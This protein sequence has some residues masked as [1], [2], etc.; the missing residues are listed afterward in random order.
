M[1]ARRRGN[2]TAPAP[3]SSRCRPASPPRTRAPVVHLSLAAACALCAALVAAD[4]LARTLRLLLFIRGAGF[5][6]SAREVFVMNAF[7]DAAAVVTPMR[8]GGEAARAVGL[9][10][11]RV[12]L[13]AVLPLLA[14][15][16][17]AYT[18]VIGVAAVGVAAWSGPDWWAEVGVRLGSSIRTLAPWLLAFAALSAL[19]VVWAHGRRRDGHVVHL[20]AAAA[21]LRGALAWPLAASVPL[22]LASA[23]ARIAILPV[24]ALTLA[25]P[26]A[27]DVLVLS[28]F[29]LVYGQLLLPTPAGAGA[30]EIAFAADAT[31]DLGD[32][33]GPVF[34]AWRFFVTLVPVLVGFGVA[35]PA[36][37]MAALRVLRPRAG[38]EAR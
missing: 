12:P 37:G 16:V 2:E 26:P 4:M 14:L 17:A 28:S 20:R 36:Y 15:E 19:A 5:R 29:A 1:R 25:D 7:G 6:L 21:S 23:A 8:M 3:V 27:L 30:V 38:P 33:L 10:H 18:V 31:G 13:S 9:L 32:G 24:L 34:L 35:I 11:A 22:T